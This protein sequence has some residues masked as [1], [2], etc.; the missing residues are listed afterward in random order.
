MQTPMK[1]NKKKE[2]PM[3][4]LNR[5]QK[6]GA[7]AL[8][9]STFHQITPLDRV[10][11]YYANPFWKEPRFERPY[12]L[13][14]NTSGWRGSTCEGQNCRGKKTGVLN[15]Y[16]THNM[17][18]LGENVPDKDPSLPENMILDALQQVEGNHC[19]AHLNFSGKFRTAG[20]ELSLLQ[21]FT[22]GFFLQLDV[23]V[24]FLEIRNICYTDLSPSL[25]ATPNKTQPEWQS[26]LGAFQSIL[27]LY[28]LDIRTC[29]NKGFGDF[30]ILFGWTKNY[31]NTEYFD[32]ID[33]TVKFGPLFP[34]GKRKN[35]HSVF[36]LPLG[37]DGHW[38][39]SACFDLSAGLFEWLTFGGHLQ[40]LPLFPRTK[41][42]RM[43]T[44][45]QQSGMIKLSKGCAKVKP[46]IVTHAGVFLQADHI[47]H[48]LSLT[49][50]YSYAR[51]G[52]KKICPCNTKKF[53]PAIVNSD[54]MFKKWTVHTVHFQAD[55]DFMQEHH[56]VG[57][58]VGVFVDWH[59]GGTRTFKTNRSGILVG[60]DFLLK[61]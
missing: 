1:Q 18:R 6:I 53:N 45:A 59:V 5:A 15:I 49:T 36:S 23:P 39:L 42:I 14:F 21:N 13:T 25:P 51:Q 31:E 2:T 57:A 24:R 28:E 44:A 35:I 33:W 40:V 11:F 8:L 48:G 58:Q 38:G 34:T 61:G 3:Y 27:K 60:F 43:K 56:T 4:R 20:T 12:L 22:H 55:Y 16:G 29:R 26:F 41:T 9:A 10:H 30:S 50:G 7:F 17:K 54:Q 47:T 32:F 52:N 37:Y 46:G 19:F